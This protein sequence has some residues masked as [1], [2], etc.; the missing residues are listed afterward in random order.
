VDSAEEDRSSVTT[1]SAG[2]SLIIDLATEELPA[3]RAEEKSEK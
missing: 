3:V 2:G 1:V